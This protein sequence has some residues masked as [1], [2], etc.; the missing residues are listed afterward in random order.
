M[1]F[2]NNFIDHLTFLV[3]KWRMKRNKQTVIIRGSCKMCGKCCQGICLFIDKKWLKKEKQFLNIKNKYKYLSRFEIC[4][5]TESGYLKFA[6]KCLSDKGICMDYENRPDLCKSFPA[7][8]IFLQYGQLPEGCGFRM[9]T[10]LDFEK[11][12]EQAITGE[13]HYKVDCSND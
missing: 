3:R 9:S 2:L 10:E 7:P 8:N 6:C 1:S 12:L 5:K 13:D 4:G 11:V